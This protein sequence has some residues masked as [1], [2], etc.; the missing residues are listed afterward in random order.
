MLRT[1]LI[2]KSFIRMAFIF[3]IGLLASCIETTA[4]GEGEDSSGNNAEDSSGNNAEDSRED[5][6]TQQPDLSTSDPAI[7]DPAIPDPAIPDPAIPDPDANNDIPRNIAYNG[8]STMH[9]SLSGQNTE[10][11]TSPSASHDPSLFNLVGEMYKA[12]GLTG[13]SSDFEFLIQGSIHIDGMR[14]FDNI[15]TTSATVI[16]LSAYGGGSGILEDPANADSA[17]GW[18]N[19]MVNAAEAAQARGITP[20]MFQAWG[21]SG[22]EG[23]FHN[24]KIN[25]DALQEKLGILVV[26][27]GEVVEA[28]H[29]L[30]SSYTTNTNSPGGAYVPPVKH[31]FS[32]DTNDNF[33]GS[34]AMAYANALAT[35]KCLTGISAVNN[36]FVIPSGGAAGDQY[37]MSQTFINDIIQTVDKIQLESLITGL[38]DGA[39][40]IANNFSISTSHGIESLINISK[41]SNL[42]DDTAII[43]DNFT[44]TSFENSHFSNIE[45]SQHQLRL[46]PSN[47]FIG[48]TKVVVDY[49]DTQGQ[50][51]EF[52]ITITVTAEAEVE[53]Q[54]IIIGF[55]DGNWS[56]FG[57][58]GN[59]YNHQTTAAGKVINGIRGFSALTTQGNL[60]DT[61]GLGVG[62]VTALTS[63]NLIGPGYTANSIPVVIDYGPYPEL[64][65]SLSAAP[66][67]STVSFSI[68]GLAANASFRINI[69]GSYGD[70]AV[71]IVAV[72]VNGVVGQ[73]DSSRSSANISEFEET[74]NS[75]NS[76]QL[77]IILS[78]DGTSSASH[79]GLSYVHINR[80]IK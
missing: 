79:W 50:S 14:A 29:L 64:Y 65:D 51:I 3:L 17:D 19:G 25:S 43:L 58:S 7:P 13:Y 74:V 16:V 49:T 20:I 72:N 5:N 70:D 23:S 18:I 34:Y 10:S 77:I 71:N 33:H 6:Q 61:Q 32:G 4:S 30:N 48:E 52:E 15:N 73:Y 36:A 46:T 68:N 60:Q 11:S 47:S 39:E 27:T 9:N 1:L 78:S 24:A 53:S 40:P 56:S 45:L 44:L 38:E 67:G 76:G 55:G 57:S 63:G 8:W 59:L 41:E 28:L 37:G 26:R 31:L 69:A 54:E 2:R 22:T 21:S 75:N 80:I 62:F 66:K 35:F 42:L 12:N